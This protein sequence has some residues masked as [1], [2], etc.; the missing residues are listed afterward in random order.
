MTLDQLVE[1]CFLGKGAFGRVTLMQRQ[2]DGAK[3]AMKIINKKKAVEL[4]VVPNLKR[5]SQILTSMDSVLILKQYTTLQD[6]NNLF[7]ILEYI[8]GGELASVV[9][10]SPGHKLRVNSAKF[11][12]AS[13]VLALEYLAAKDII[14]RD[15]KLENI[16]LDKR[17]F[18]KI[19][20]FGFAKVIPVKERTYTF[21]GTP[22][23]VAPE[24]ILGEGYGNSADIWALGIIVYEMLVGYTPFF[25]PEDSDPDNIYKRIC[26][27]VTEV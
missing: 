4:R 12:T 20:D 19:V 7:M 22:E 21:C 8:S 1:V 5:E 14:H 25:D 9:K 13:I 27:M 18:V 16:L 6:P 15:L 3:F 11:Y 23:Y 2:S 17:G 24:V 26:N 10:N